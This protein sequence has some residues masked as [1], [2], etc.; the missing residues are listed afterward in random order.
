M[1]FQKEMEK[2]ENNLR[3]SA[4]INRQDIIETKCVSDAYYTGK[5]IYRTTVKSMPDYYVMSL[6]TVGGKILGNIRISKEEYRTCVD[7]FW[8]DDQGF[9]SHFRDLILNISKDEI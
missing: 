2:I 7:K 4:S 3:F 9:F 1:D 6:R 8:D 5:A